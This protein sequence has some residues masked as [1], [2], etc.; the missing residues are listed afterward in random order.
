M[1]LDIDTNEQK[2][3]NLDP[4]TANSRSRKAIKRKALYLFPW[5]DKVR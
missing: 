5:L 2:E 3:P 1:A 4:K